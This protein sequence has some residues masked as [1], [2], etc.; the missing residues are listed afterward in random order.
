MGTWSG[1]W[2]QGSDLLQFAFLILVCSVDRPGPARSQL[3]AVEGFAIASGFHTQTAPLERADP[4][5]NVREGLGAPLL[6]VK[7]LGEAG[8]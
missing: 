7:D 1:D 3:L 8:K 6:L 5:L 2:R 4:A